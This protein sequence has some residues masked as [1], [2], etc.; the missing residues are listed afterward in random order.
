MKHFE[1]RCIENRREM[2]KFGG[3]VQGPVSNLGLVLISGPQDR[4]GP[5]QTVCNDKSF[6]F[7][8]FRV[9]PSARERGGRDEVRGDA[10][11][12]GLP[13]VLAVARRGHPRR[14]GDPEGEEGLRPRKRAPPRL[15]GQSGA[16][17]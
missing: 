4:S 3:S 16:I 11:G 2:E 13:G 6:L 12:P 5:D 8:F 15:S 7:F 10:A 17:P 9:H 14:P 1:S